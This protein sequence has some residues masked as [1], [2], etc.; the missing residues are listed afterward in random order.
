MGRGRG[1]ELAC[2]GRQWSASQ[3]KNTK[4]ET[5]PSRPFEF[6]FV[7]GDSR[8]ASRPPIAFAVS[9]SGIREPVGCAALAER[10]QPVVLAVLT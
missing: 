3:I 10:L 6:L 5:V 4:S 7:Q 9:S 2:A 1:G 8:F